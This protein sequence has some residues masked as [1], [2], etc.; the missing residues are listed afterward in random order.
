[1]KLTHTQSEYAIELSL[2]QYGKWMHYNE[3]YSVFEQAKKFPTV[4]EIN[5]DGHF[6][7][8]IFITIEVDEYGHTEII[9]VFDWIRSIVGDK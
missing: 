2:D 4:R 3:R 7:P 5:F 1:M 9:K 6:G 8:Y